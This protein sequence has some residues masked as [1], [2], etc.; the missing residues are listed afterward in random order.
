MSKK[1]ALTTVVLFSLLS[2]VI[3]G[4]VGVFATTQYPRLTAQESE[5]ISQVNGTSAYDY[6]LELER[7]A[8]DHNVSEYAFRS[9][10]SPGATYTADWIKSQFESLGLETHLESF[11]FTNWSMPS[12]PTL[13]IDQDGNADTIDDQTSIKCFQSAHFSWSTS[14]EGIFGDLV[15]LP[16]PEDLTWNDFRG[17]DLMPTLNSS[18]WM[19]DTT[20]K[21]LLI[22]REVNWYYRYRWF[23]EKK[24]DSQ[25]PAALIY[26]YWYDWMNFTPPLYGSMAGVT[27]WNRKLPTGWVDYNDGLLIRN[28]E[29]RV[30]VSASVKIPAKIGYGTHYNVVGKLTGSANPEKAIIISGHYD[31]VMDAGFCD[32]GAGV[33]GVIELARVFTDAARMGVYKPEQTLIFIGFT[34]EELGFIGAIEYIRQHKA[35]MKSISALINLDC[36]G[37]SNLTVSETFPD[38]NGL[39]LDEIVL[40]AAQDLGVKAQLESPGGSDQEAFRNPKEATSYYRDYW[41]SDPG[42][43]DTA[44]VKS[45]TM[46]GSYPLFYSDKFTGGEPGWIHTAYDNST[47]TVTLNWVK[48][49]DLEAHIKVA[50]LSVMR[51]FAAL[52][53]P[54]MS[55]LIIGSA[56]GSVILAVAIVLE[57]SKVK[58]ALA[59]LYDHITYYM[60]TREF[61]YVFLLTAFLLFS[62]YA[63]HSRVGNV[64][65]ISNGVPTVLS[66]RFFGYPF[67][68]FGIPLRLSITQ[69]DLEAVTSELTTNP[70]TNMPVILW[71]GLLLSIVL[72]FLVAFGITYLVMRL[73]YAYQSRKSP[74]AA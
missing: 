46:L 13:V 16:L 60:D 14:E 74:E 1:A 30:D 12:Q 66:M 23:F 17:G 5:V 40:K 31:T 24:L 49:E 63:A 29:A 44:R 51:F 42:I 71:F 20:G 35:E 21:I 43:N 67:E 68:M 59:W 38:D 64:E 39:E 57:R 10:G 65:V 2:A 37:H 70:A 26:T 27:L 34:G 61:F 19:Q 33:A 41:G 3:L 7:I 54:L 72:F 50:A 8:L 11:E 4:E 48:T 47:S 9:A 6:D 28:M 53:N 62:S 56:I 32:N 22:G 15:V 25:P 36:I 52:Y 73:N 18:A 45:S 55:Q 69:L 58:A